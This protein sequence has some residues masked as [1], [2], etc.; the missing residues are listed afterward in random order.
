[1]QIIKVNSRLKN[2]NPKHSIKVNDFQRLDYAIAAYKLKET[3]PALKIFVKRLEL[4]ERDDATNMILNYAGNIE[5]HHSYI[6][7]KEDKKFED[8]IFFYKIDKLNWEVLCGAYILFNSFAKQRDA[9]YEEYLNYVRIERISQV[10]YQ[11]KLEDFKKELISYNDNGIRFFNHKKFHNVLRKNKTKLF[12]VSYDDEAKASIITFKNVEL[13]NEEQGIIKYEK[14]IL[15]IQDWSIIRY[16]LVFSDFIYDTKDV[17]LSKIILHPYLKLMSLYPLHEWIKLGDY[18][19]FGLFL[20]GLVT[21]YKDNKTIE[22]IIPLSEIIKNY[23]DL[24]YLWSQKR[25]K[26]KGIE[27]KLSHN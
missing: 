12:H 23:F 24:R 5:T 6:L 15:Y 16:K 14:I 26:P 7:I 1:M 27:E 3:I 11:K 2:V 19:S 21:E 10:Q 22:G 25:I 18:E 9:L 4:L 8:I 13:G 20:F 17:E